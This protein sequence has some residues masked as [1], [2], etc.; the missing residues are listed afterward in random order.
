MTKQLFLP[1]VPYCWSVAAIGAALGLRMLLHPLL[2]DNRP[3]LT[4]LAAVAV[5]ASIGGRGPA[6]FS[7][8]ASYFVAN[9]YLIPPLGSFYFNHTSANDWA[10]VLVFV[11]LGLLISEPIVAMQHAQHQAE[12]NAAEVAQLLAAAKRR[13][14]RKIGFWPCWRTSC[15]IR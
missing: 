15:A 5:A 8:I 9:Y 7:I 1:M 3:F 10:N 14:S 13:I 2:G 11:G 12:V 4:F 6:L